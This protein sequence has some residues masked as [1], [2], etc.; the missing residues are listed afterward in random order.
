MVSVNGKNINVAD[1]NNNYVVFDNTSSVSVG[2]GDVITAIG[3][4][5]KYQ[6]TEEIKVWKAADIIVTASAPKAITFTQPSG[7][8]GDAGCSF[9]VSV[10]GSPISS[11]DTVA[12]GTTVTLTA[13]AGTDYEFTSWTVEGATVADASSATTTFEMGNSAVTI[14]AS[15]SSTSGGGGSS[16]TTLTNANIVAAGDPGTS[17]TLWNNLED[18]NGNI[19][20]ANAIKN[21]HS[22]ATSS[23]HYLQIKK[24][25]SSTA[26]YIH[27]P[28]LGTKITSIT[29]TVSSSSQPMTGGANTST[30]YFS[31]SNS[32]SAT[33]TGVASGTG[34][35][36]VTIDCSSL[37][38]NT[39]Y[40][41]ASGAVRIWDIEVTYDN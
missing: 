1:G 28:E 13:A 35:S 34:A 38:L 7:A 26:Y 17:Y 20:T 19:F 39:G 9:T 29:M 4:V 10:G 41:T 21:K 15:F 2:V 12:S 37:N 23:Y 24:Y 6:T 16:T 30:L 33:G 32:T 36:S 31:A 18:E 3:T 11:G 40:I 14:S 22:N 5:T 25:A 27:I 8:A